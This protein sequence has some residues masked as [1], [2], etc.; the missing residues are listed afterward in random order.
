[1]AEETERDCAYK[2]YVFSHTQEVELECQTHFAI[3]NPRTAASSVLVCINA[4]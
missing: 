2:L 1:M 3:V 4:C